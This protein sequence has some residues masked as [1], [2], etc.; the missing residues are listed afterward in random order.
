MDEPA[1]RYVVSRLRWWRS[2]QK[3]YRRA[4]GEVPLASFATF[5]AADADRWAREGRA[6]VWVNPFTCG[7][8]VHHWTSLD[9][10]RLRDWLMDRGVTPPDAP[11][12][13]RTDWAAW[14]EKGRQTLSDEQKAVVWE[15]LDRV[16]FYAVAARPVRP[17]VYAVVKI[18]WEY[19][20]QWQVAYTDG[21]ELQTVYRRRA[22]AEAACERL[23]AAER[24]NWGEGSAFDLDYRL[25]DR[26][27]LFAEPPPAVDRTGWGD[28]LVSRDA[29]PFY[30]VIELELEAADGPRA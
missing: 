17:V 22:A 3:D 1:T 13:G 4:P 26:R 10:P 11:T 21:G 2:Y 5:D 12:G 20:D 23:N 18:D 30:E 7:G 25:R 24:A 15:A 28:N 29:A 6:R 19:N 16:R 8:A 14:W 9:E 27:D